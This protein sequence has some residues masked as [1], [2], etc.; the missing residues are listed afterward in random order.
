MRGFLLDE[1]GDVVVKGNDI[2]M[3]QGNELLAQKVR[4]VLGTNK[5]E[6]FANTDEGIDNKV[7]LGK[8]NLTAQANKYKQGDLTEAEELKLISQLQGKENEQLKLAKLLEQRLD[9]D[10]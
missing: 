8:H 9:G 7:L 6:W 10:I 1:S 4:L 5:G 2:A 3:L